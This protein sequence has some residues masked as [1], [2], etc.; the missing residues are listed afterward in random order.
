MTRQD[1]RRTVRGDERAITV[2]DSI[3]AGS[4]VVLAV[5]L[6]AGLGLGVLYAPSDG[7]TDATRANF[8]YQH[9]A[10]DS[11]LVVTFAK[12]DPITAGDLSIVSGETNRTWAMLANTT[13]SEEV[14]EGSTIQLTGTGRFGKP[15]TT[16]TSVRIVYTGGNETRV[17]SSWPPNSSAG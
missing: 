17:L 10:D 2:T 14:S 1:T 7:G 12:G 5:V 8:S 9:F 6:A 13:E 3:A 11:V 16:D 15:I 4:L